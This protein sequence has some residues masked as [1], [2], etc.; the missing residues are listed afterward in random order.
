MTIGQRIMLVL[1]MPCLVVAF[2]LATTH[3]REA[4]YDC[5]TAFRATNAVAL[6]T[7]IVVAENRLTPVDCSARLTDRRGV[8][9][10]FG[11]V[12]VILVTVVFTS[13]P[14]SDRAWRRRRREEQEH[15]FGRLQAR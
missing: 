10:A 12:A 8:A 6:S 1:A 4:G 13:R 15:L 2:A 5:G 7:D 9:G 14:T 3:V 11:L